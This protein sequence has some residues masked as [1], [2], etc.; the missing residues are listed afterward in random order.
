MD[1]ESDGIPRIAGV[2]AGSTEGANNKLYE[3]TIR[4]ILKKVLPKNFF[5]GKNRFEQLTSLNERLPLINWSEMEAMPCEVAIIGLYKYR[6]CSTKFVYDMISRCLIP[7][8][9]LN[10]VFSFTSDFYFP[11]LSKG[12]YIVTE[13][14][15]NIAD[16]SDLKILKRNLPI[17][18]TEIK[19]GVISCES[20]IRILEIKGFSSDEKSVLIQDNILAL[21]N[22]LL[23]RLP[24][25][26]DRDIYNEMQHFLV[27]CHEDF[28]A[29]H[30]YR[31]MARMIYLQYL[32]RKSLRNTKKNTNPRRRLVIKLIK[33]RLHSPYGTR[34]VLALLIGLNFLNENEVFGEKQIIK[35]IKNLLPAVNLI[36]DSFIAN[37]RNTGGALILYIEMEK[38]VEELFTCEEIN[39][40]NKQLPI[41]LKH[42]I[43]RLMH[44][45][46]M[47]R[48]EEEVM[49]NILTLGEQLKQVKDLPQVIISFDEQTDA[50]VSFT[51]ILLRISKQNSIPIRDLFKKVSDGIEFIHDRTKVIGFIRK[52]EAKEANVFHIR[53]N[54]SKFL[55]RNHSLDLYKARQVIVEELI[56]LLGNIRDYNGGMI[57][58]EN[59]VFSSLKML[60]E[61]I[62]YYNELLLENFFYSLTP[63][64]MRSVLN[65][66]VLKIIFCMLMDLIEEDPLK[67]EKYLIKVIH[68]SEFMYCMV[69]SNDSSFR[70]QVNQTIE[71]LE[72]ARFQLASVYL[73]HD[74]ISFLGYLYRC[75]NLEKRA[76]FLDA[77]RTTMQLWS[78]NSILV[79]D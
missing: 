61:K 15:V 7:G 30:E 62:G 19:M 69:R 47:P 14:I 11:E 46:F 38:G 16:F 20:A 72:V 75:D 57:S 40:L 23:N 79:Q 6:L 76:F 9:H 31:H 44:P 54:K 58:K 60:L 3:A 34:T 51:V 29:I 32:F 21:L 52:K 25:I 50:T 13:M 26:F 77:I 4:N 33:T 28:K 2:F 66:S 49:R 8:K 27:L 55:R 78:R 68:D 48:N 64:I 10:I 59:E 18:A 56:S 67:K 39:R 41:E 36:E 37:Q 53:L 73:S 35:G 63:V 42:C 45:I 12:Q 22:R 70:L 71:K 24:Q 74:N 1:I 65:A 5:I 17:I 43:E